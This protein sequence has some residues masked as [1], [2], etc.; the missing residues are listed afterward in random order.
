MNDNPT[1]HFV[2]R[3]GD[4][5]V[6][7]AACPCLEIEGRQTE[8]LIGVVDQASSSTHQD[9]PT[10]AEGVINAIRPKTHQRAAPRGQPPSSYRC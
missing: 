2:R 6:T 4:Q 5:G 8:Q 10:L 9:A 3:N 1:G 7:L